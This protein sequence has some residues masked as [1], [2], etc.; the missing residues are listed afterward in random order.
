LPNHTHTINLP[1]HYHSIYISDHSH[2]VYIPDHTHTISI[3][4]HTHNV[5]IP[6]HTHAIEYGIY[7]G[8]IASQMVIYVD[9][10]MIGVY[11]ASVKNINLISY[12]QKNA[13]GNVMRGDHTI[14]IVPS[15]LTRIECSYQIRMFTNA[16]TGGQY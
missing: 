6:D 16:R 2:S 12:M 15:S 14:K 4:N 3:P 7:R 1:N 10:T 5:T 8:P 13:N 9:D 11:T